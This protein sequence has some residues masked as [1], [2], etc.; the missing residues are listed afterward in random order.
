MTY[1]GCTKD[2]KR[3]QSPVKLTAAE[4][5]QLKKFLHEEGAK[6]LADLIS[7][8]SSESGC[9]T[10]PQP[11]R[12]FLSEVSHNSPVCGLLQVVGSD[13]VLGIMEAI[14]SGDDITQPE[15]V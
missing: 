11:F 9:R 7:R 6:P 3:L 15:E 2:R 1:S 8:L 12:E 14:A 4:F 13:K 10:S 5:R